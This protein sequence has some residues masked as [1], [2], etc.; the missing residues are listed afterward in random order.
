MTTA[1]FLE[2]LFGGVE[3]GYVYLW[4]LPDKLSY[5]Y[6][7]DDLGAMAEKGVALSE[8]GHDVYVGVAVSREKRGAHQRIDAASASAITSLWVDIDYGETHKS[9]SLPPD[10]DAAREL[11]SIGVEPSIVVSSGYGLHGYLLFR[12]PMDAGDEA[13]KLA[14][15]YQSAIRMKASA[16]GWK[17][18][19]THD[20]ARVLR[21]PGTKNYKH[22]D[23][24]TPT[25][26]VIEYSEGMRY[27]ESE[28]DDMLPD[29]TA[30][31]HGASREALFERREYDA[32]A[33][34]IIQNCAFVRDF[35][36]GQIER[37]EPVWMAVCS[38]VLRAKDGDA[39]LMGTVKKWLGTKYDERRTDERLSHYL[40]CAPLSCTYI[41]Q[42]LGY[43]GC[44]SCVHCN[45]NNPCWFSLAKLGRAIA[46][47]RSMKA[48]NG[49]TIDDTG[50]AML[51]YIREHAETVY[52]SEAKPK[53][54]GFVREFERMFERKPKAQRVADMMNEHGMALA[55]EP[56][57]E[58]EEADK[59]TGITGIDFHCP[60]GFR[61]NLE[62]GIYKYFPTTEK[63]RQ[64]SS[65]P[66]FIDQQI[67]DIDTGDVKI[68]L[69]FMIGKKKVTHVMKRSE[70]FSSV[71]LIKL[72]DKGFNV[73]SGDSAKGIVEYLRGFDGLAH[74]QKLMEHVSSVSH[75]GWMNSECSE[76][77]LP[78]HTDYVVDMDDEGGMIAGLTAH[79]DAERWKSR[80]RLIRSYPFARAMFA[81]AFAAPLI[82]VFHARNP[83]IHLWG[84]SQ[85]GKSAAQRFALSAW[86]DP[87]RIQQTFFT[88]AN[89]LERVAKTM[90]DIPIVVNER[91]AAIGKNTRVDLQQ[92]VYMLEGGQTKGRA[93]K[94]GLQ[95][96]D[97][98]H[99]VIMTS[100]EEPISQRSSQGGV[101]NR[102]IELNVPRIL[103]PDIAESV[104]TWVEEDYGAA[105][106]EF[107]ERLIDADKAALREKHR[108]V[109]EAMKKQ[110][111]GHSE[112]H[113]AH[114]AL[115]YMADVLS[116]EWVFGE[117]SR[118][119]EASAR[120]MID[121]LMAELPL[122][123]DI[124]DT[125]R[126]KEYVADWIASNAKHFGLSDRE[127]LLAP[128]YGFFK[129][130]AWYIYRSEFEKAL[131]GSGFAPGKIIKEFADMGI[132]ETTL[133]N[134]KSVRTVTAR[135]CG[136]V[137]RYI[138]IKSVT[139]FENADEVNGN[140]ELGDFQGVS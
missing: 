131:E 61:V 103:P 4:T 83:F 32:P 64:I 62:N 44:R 19:A 138:K 58:E 71:E 111:E 7:V 79:G 82:R 29:V 129:L 136:K 130:G 91:Q 68:R 18:D 59:E 2:A 53:M 25:V 73:S 20:L 8:A 43:D 92:I 34:N 77:V 33:E 70:A 11:L 51:A 106:W 41:N 16:S 26:S 116:S 117:D 50:R 47:M 102:L 94:T 42:K 139:T 134:G 109:H 140:A 17:I 14:E 40:K 36:G 38:N 3:D 99:T 89:S 23:V 5:W 105:G 1:D 27:N 123:S 31:A 72:A 127:A 13:Q 113:I 122:K 15:R 135:H 39:I 75:I 86:G 107:V 45:G 6:S 49:G 101:I 69:M 133:M 80:A 46:W 10:M 66:I 132:I 128:E 67:K 126:A 22:R 97:T 120:G 24:G 84:T 137:G 57:A 100:G 110:Y 21:L 55:V 119:A 93:T 30:P 81:G 48:I 95:R 121:A 124:S 115:L 56:D 74:N 114:A 87:E 88:T 63:Y 78:G 35:F 54:K 12:E 65:T 104:Y 52:Q 112:T 9:K 96:R 60:G 90:K 85:S 118:A 76:F 98:W 28:V 108:A 125:K 37:S